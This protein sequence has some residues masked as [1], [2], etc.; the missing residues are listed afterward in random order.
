MAPGTHSFPGLIWVEE[1]GG[2]FGSQEQA[3]AQGVQNLFPTSIP[4][5]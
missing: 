1:G 3:D 4:K 2:W 5:V